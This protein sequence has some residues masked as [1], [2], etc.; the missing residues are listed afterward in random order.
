MNSYNWLVHHKIIFTDFI[1]NLQQ[2]IPIRQVGPMIR[3]YHHWKKLQYATNLIGL[4]AVVAKTWL[5]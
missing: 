4:T 2:Y 3:I 1:V 5:S